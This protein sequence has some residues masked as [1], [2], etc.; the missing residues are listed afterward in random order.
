MDGATWLPHGPSLRCSL[1]QGGVP[2]LLFPF[3]EETFLL[4]AGAFWKGKLSLLSHKDTVL[5][6]SK[7]KWILSSNLSS[8]GPGEAVMYDERDGHS[9]TPPLTL[10]L[11]P[12]STSKLVLRNEFYTQ[13][14]HLNKEG[15]HRVR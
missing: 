14:L 2:H 11:H 13:V 8:V 15:Q 1:W 12:V 9:S 3:P 10:A 6:G 5:S 4:K 7:E